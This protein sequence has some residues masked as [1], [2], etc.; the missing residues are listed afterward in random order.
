MAET[1]DDL[2]VRIDAA[3]RRVEAARASERAVV[4]RLRDLETVVEASI[5]ELDTLLTGAR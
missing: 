2:I 3:L 4:D 1:A 5:G